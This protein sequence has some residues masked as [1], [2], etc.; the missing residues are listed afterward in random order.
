MTFSI[1]R[2]GREWANA[3]GF[4]S[5]TVVVM[6]LLYLSCVY[7]RRNSQFCLPSER[8]VPPSMTSRLA[9]PLLHRW[10]WLLYLI[11]LTSLLAPCANT[12]RAQG[13]LTTGL[14]H[15]GTISPAGDSDTWTFSANAGE[16]IIIRVGEM[17]QTNN[18]TPRIRLFN[19]LGTLQASA[20]SSVAA[21]VA[22]TATNTGTFTVI[23]DD[24]IGTVATGTYRLTLANPPD[25]VSISPGDEGGPMTNGVMHTGVIDVGD[26]DLWTFNA[27]AGDNI[28]VRM[29]ET[30]S[31]SSLTPQLRLYGPNGALQIGNASCTER[32]EISVGATNL[33]K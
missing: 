6:K 12:A 23:V 32:A 21:E 1:D 30:T 14:T 3:S 24:S 11:L 18:F 17:T 5:H 16:P 33:R 10:L 9:K 31:G 20:S 2:S 13:A 25:A 4:W 29:G 7:P 19:P 28:V 15:T 22:V 8:R 27:N 26:L